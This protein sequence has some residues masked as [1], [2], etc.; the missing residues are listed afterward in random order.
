[1]SWAV[2]RR[3]HI[4]NE[5]RL[6]DPTASSETIETT[7]LAITQTKD[8]AITL[9]AGAGERSE[10]DPDARYRIERFDQT[11]AEIIAALDQHHAT[12]EAAERHGVETYDW[13][14]W[15]K[16]WHEERTRLLNRLDMIRHP[17][18]IIHG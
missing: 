5:E 4:P 18:R 17:K 8:Q 13:N 15:A 1:M 11:E 10:L 12:W 9:L 7:V 16:E 3:Y 14:A 6:F 2:V